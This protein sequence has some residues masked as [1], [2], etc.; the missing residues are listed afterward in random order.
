[1]VACS[2]D[3]VESIDIFPDSAA[4]SLTI[5]NFVYAAPVYSIVCWL[6]ASLVQH[7]HLEDAPVHVL[8]LVRLGR[9]CL[10]AGL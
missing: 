10:G 8:A 7:A 3:S 5:F 2:C 6:H 9:Q 1:M 4:M